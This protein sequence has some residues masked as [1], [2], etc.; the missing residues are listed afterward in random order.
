MYIYEEEPELIARHILLLSVLLDETLPA[1]DRMETLLELHGNVFLRDKTAN[2][3]GEALRLCLHLGLHA[4]GLHAVACLTSLHTLW[5][6]SCKLS[7]ALALAR[8]NAWLVYG[9][10]VCVINGIN[11][12]YRYGTGF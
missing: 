8:F 7:H 3:L 6:V 9:S 12:S 5:S 10:F 11:W 2:Y 1:R 4:P